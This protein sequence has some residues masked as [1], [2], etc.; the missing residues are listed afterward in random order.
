[1]GGVLSVLG[2]LEAA[3]ESPLVR[4]ELSVLQ[5][6]LPAARVHSL[7]QQL[8]ELTSG[9]GVLESS[10]GGYQPVRGAIPS[11]PRTDHNPLDPKE[12]IRKVL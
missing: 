8:P 5:T 12:Y 1:M 6:V 3:V 2:Q 4:G 7:R 11:R 9:E 10:F